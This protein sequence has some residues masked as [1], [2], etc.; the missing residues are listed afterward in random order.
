VPSSGTIAVERMESQI[1]KKVLGASKPKGLN[2]IAKMGLSHLCLR[3]ENLSF[4]NN[5]II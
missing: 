1:I 4:N 2:R 5:Y 3:E